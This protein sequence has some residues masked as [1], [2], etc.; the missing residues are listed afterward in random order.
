VGFQIDQCCLGLHGHN[1]CECLCDANWIWDG[2]YRMLI[3]DFTLDTAVGDHPPPVVRLGTR[4]LNS[5]IPRCLKKYTKLFEE[6]LTRHS[7]MEK[8]LACHTWLKDEESFLWRVQQ[9][10]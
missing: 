2:D 4:K 10:R 5:K 6:S 7:F 8:L 1:N 9:D 3:V